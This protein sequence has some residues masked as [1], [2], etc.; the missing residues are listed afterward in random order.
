MKHTIF[1]LFLLL[2]LSAHS[3][4][5]SLVS[6]IEEAQQNHGVVAPVDRE[7]LI[8]LV[9]LRVLPPEVLERMDSF[10]VEIRENQPLVRLFNTKNLCADRQWMIPRDFLM[11]L[12]WHI[13]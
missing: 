9:Q 12:G 8:K 5:V 7:M 6:I 13:A 2:P 1:S 11:L 3:Q 4:C 10:Y